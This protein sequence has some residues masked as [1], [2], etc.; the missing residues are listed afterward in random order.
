MTWFKVELIAPPSHYMAPLM[1]YVRFMIDRNNWCKEH[2]GE[3]GVS[4]TQRSISGDMRIKEYSFK[5]SKIATWFAL[6]W[7]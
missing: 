3:Y 1:E 2:A 4:W 7:E 6:R 5:D